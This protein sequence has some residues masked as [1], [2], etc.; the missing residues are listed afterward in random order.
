MKSII[1]S[2][3]LTAS[4][5]LI[6]SCSEKKENAYQTWS[7]YLGG[8]D[9]NHF[10]VLDQINP[11]NVGS[12]KLAWTYQT[13][14]SGQMQ[15]NPQ[16]HD[17]VLYG[18]S[19]ALRVFALDAATGKE[20]WTY[21]EP[22][23]QWYSLSRGVSL[24]KGKDETRLFFTAGSFLYALDAKSG[25][26]ITSF[27]QNGSI[28]LHTGLPESAAGK[29]ILSATPGTIFEN[30][31]IMPLRL[32]EDFDAPAGDIRAFDVITGKLMWSFHTIPHPGEEGYETWENKEAWKNE[33][34]GAANN[35]SGMSV[36]IE[37]GTLFV[38]TGSAAPDFY[39]ARRLGS[40]LFA[41]CLIAL[42]ARTGKKKWHY[43]F[44]HHDIWDRDCPAPPNLIT[45]TRG[46]KKI[47]AVAQLTKQA[48]VFVFD[49]ETGEPLFDIEEKPFPPSELEGEQ[50]WPTQ[51]IPVAPAPFARNA[52]QL[53]ENDISPY[54][55]NKQELLDFF[56]S[57]DR[58][59][60]APPG[61]KPVLL[62]P[63]YDGGAEWGGTGASPEEGIIYV[64]SNEMAWILQMRPGR[65]DEQVSLGQSVYE[66]RCSVCHQANRS[67]LPAS[68]YPSLIDI[69]SKLSREEIETLVHTG[70]GRMPGFPQL[71]SSDKRALVD[72]L[73]GVEKKGVTTSIEVPPVMRYRHTGYDKFLD[74]NGLPAISPPWGTLNAIDLNTGKYL[75]KITYGET[76]HLAKQGYTQTG[77]ESYGGPVVTQNGL[78]FISGTKDK[79]IRAYNR[80]TGE[81]LWETELPAAAFAT[82]ATYMAGGRQFVAIACG[83][84]KLG[85]PKGNYVVAFALPET[86]QQ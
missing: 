45:V 14:D 3:L 37:S 75:W 77:S 84:E 86:V 17:G 38:P 11:D 21:G 22:L 19:A 50:A 71:S 83:G 79:L 70:K 31:I 60:F 30:L 15:M 42:D 66:N 40:N 36:D 65:S 73:F 57:A 2:T 46:G 32:S 82:P 43:Q 54:A 69:Q 56:R 16:I 81:K 33:E 18:I 9:R 51:P 53:T 29:F 13:P 61:L 76:P 59:F 64:N 39:G 85:A 6:F 12:M 58:R 4:V 24:W 47:K 25:K 74:A 27:G 7:D 68:G 63:G 72:F 48:Y 62:L 52:S 55:P 10:S 35:W 41:N 80:Y 49:R 5:W 20:L 44:V 78:L 34:T 23:K 28:D 1:K 26:P 67:G 8:P